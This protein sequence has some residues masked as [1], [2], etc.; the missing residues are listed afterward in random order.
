M[1]KTNV[2]KLRFIRA[3]EP[4]GREYT[5]Y[6]NTDVVVGDLVEIDV[7]KQ[8]VVTQI[9]VPEEEIAP[10]KD[11][12]KTILGKV[13]EETK[14]KFK[15]QQI[16]CGQYKPYGDSFRVWDIETDCTDSEKVLE[17]CFTD[18]YQRKIP[19]G[20]EWHKNIRYGTGEKSGDANY[21]FAGYYE[22]SKTDTGYKFTVCEP[23][24]D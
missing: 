23:F 3:G 1:M 14:A 13:P 4:S 16:H 17:Y 15:A 24:A 20:V 2:I 5:Y 12:A 18:L 19:E 9:N 8:G 10:F 7:N 22:L 6:S 11:R 21:Y